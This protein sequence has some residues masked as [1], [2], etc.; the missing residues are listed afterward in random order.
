ME[1]WENEKCCGNKSRRRV[2]PR[3]F[4]VLTNFHE[5]FY[6]EVNGNTEYMF[7]ISFRKHRDEKKKNNFLTLIIKMYILFACAIIT[8]TARASSV[9]DLHLASC[10]RS[11]SSATN[12]ARKNTKSAAR[13]SEEHLLDF[14][15]RAVSRPAPN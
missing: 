13:G 14:F 2:F 11:V 3:L 8:S 9:S 15:S 5:C 4:R 6:T 1:V 7:A 10:R 12:G